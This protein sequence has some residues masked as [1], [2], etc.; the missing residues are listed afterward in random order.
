M[1][2]SASTSTAEQ[3]FLIERVFDAPRSLVW[4]AWSE[5]ERLAQWWGPKGCTI[6]VA[7][8][9]FWPGGIFH[10]AM[11]MPNGGEM[12]GRF[13]YRE[14]APPERLVWL[15]SF[16]DS[17]GD[18]ARAPFNPSWPLEM[19]VTVTLTESS[20]RTALTLRAGAFNATE[21]ERHVFAAGL[22]SMQHGFGGTFDQLTD[23]LK[24]A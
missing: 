7:K 4:K 18:L 8:L 9:E 17:S 22:A 23:Y 13:I 6:R 19:L 1:A 12:W 16:S 5:P 2:S 11:G 21:A 24:K 3:P 14:T 10:Y 20:G 15:N